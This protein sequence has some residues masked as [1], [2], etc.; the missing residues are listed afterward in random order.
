MNF[1]AVILAGGRSRRM[2]RDKAWLEVDG[3]PLLARALAV[4]REAGPREVFISSRADRGDAALGCPV[5]LDRE[6]DLGPLGGIERALQAAASPLVLVLAVDLP[7]MTGGF[8]RKLLAGISCTTRE[9]PSD[10]S[11]RRKEADAFSIA[12]IPPPYVGGYETC[13]ICGPD[14]RDA[15][16]GVVPELNGEL[17]PLVAVYPRRCHR[18]ASDLLADGRRAARDFAEACLRE[19]AVRTLPVEPADARYFEN[20]NTLADAVKAVAPAVAA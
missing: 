5:L 12:P 13:E 4:L 14:A 15:L 17:E 8:L 1:S 3:Q 9:T 11:R 6:P 10:R 16:I 7:Y 2:G 20:W 18:I 19:R